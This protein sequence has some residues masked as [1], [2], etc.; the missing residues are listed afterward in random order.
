MAAAVGLVLMSFGGCAT[1]SEGVAGRELTSFPTA[2][3]IAPTPQAQELLRLAEIDFKRVRAGELPTYA[4]FAGAPRVGRRVFK[5]TGYSI[6]DD[7]LFLPED[8][9]MFHTSGVTLT[10][11]PPITSATVSY[12]EV[13]RV[14]RPLAQ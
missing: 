7:A 4:K 2:R 11:G 12:R 14:R 13:R 9:R 6:A 10:L 5:N 3:D 8:D 1:P